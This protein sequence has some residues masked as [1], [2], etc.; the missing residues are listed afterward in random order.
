MV[1]VMRGLTG[2][3]GCNGLIMIFLR[4]L[5]C[6]TQGDLEMLMLRVAYIISV[7]A[8]ASWAVKTT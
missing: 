5:T 2:N 7:G 8:K 4:L 3:L 1:T 6:E